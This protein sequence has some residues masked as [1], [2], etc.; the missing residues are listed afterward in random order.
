ML[1]RICL[2]QW[3]K[4][5]RHGRAQLLQLSIEMISKSIEIFS[6]DSSKL[7]FLNSHVYLPQSYEK[8]KKH[9]QKSWNTECQ[10][11]FPGMKFAFWWNWMKWPIKF[12]RC[13]LYCVWAFFQIV[14]GIWAP[15]ASFAATYCMMRGF[16]TYLSQSLEGGE[17][18]MPRRLAREVSV[19]I[20]LY[21]SWK[22]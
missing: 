10:L 8:E 13:I 3:E 7:K 18:E 9:P 6:N 5:S 21:I 12:S 17:R 4:N 20:I 2:N 19:W 15:G 14:L 11:F 16:L 22:F 1:W